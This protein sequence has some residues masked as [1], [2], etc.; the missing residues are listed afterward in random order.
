MLGQAA[1]ARVE[2]RFTLDRMIAEYR[3]AYY[4]AVA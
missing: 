1:R 4:A 2:E 3:D